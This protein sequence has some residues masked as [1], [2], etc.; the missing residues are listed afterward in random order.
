MLIGSAAMTNVRR[1]QHYLEAKQEQE[2]QCKETKRR[3]DITWEHKA[4][5]F[6]T[7]SIY[8]LSSAWLEN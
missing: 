5:S 1:I 2:N 4:I 6:C 7:S 8:C 3:A